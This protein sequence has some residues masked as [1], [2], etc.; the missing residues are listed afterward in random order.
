MWQLLLGGLFFMATTIANAA[1][2]TILD[3]KVK[4]IKDGSKEQKLGELHK[5]KAYLIV[6]TASQCGYTPQY[7]GLQ[8][9]QDEYA[10]KGLLVLGFPSNDFGGQEPGSNAEIKKFCE[11][12]F[13]V[14][15]PLFEKSV[16]KGP[17]K[18]E[19]YQKL[20][21]EA[22]VKGEVK[23][24]FEKFLVDGNGKVVKRY[25]SNVEPSDSELKADIQKLL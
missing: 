19:L 6:N 16:V 14:S 2:P 15:F 12:R 24:N 4:S 13:K 8:K 9:L 11:A 18:S 21:S 1:S 7:A 22:P 17:Q 5:A 25:L 20:T 23:W 10:A 3:V